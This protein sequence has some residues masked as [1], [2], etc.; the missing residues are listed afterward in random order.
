MPTKTNRE[1]YNERILQATLDR[2]Y[3]AFSNPSHLKEWWGPE[4]FTN[5]IHEFDL[6]PGGKWLL[7][8]HGPNNVN[9]ENASVFKTIKPQQL[10]SW[11]R[12]SKPLFD[13][14]VEFIE[15][16]DSETQISFRMIFET[17][18]DCEKLRTFVGPKNE[19]NFDRLE[20][21]LLNVSV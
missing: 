18:S 3:H 4:G 1:I 11:S 16:N 14:E 5:T 20:K 21:V 7:T 2:A 13:M 12:T 15:L 19:E 8:M 17:A 6:R 9:Y 10:V